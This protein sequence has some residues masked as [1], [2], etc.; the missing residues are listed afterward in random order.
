MFG[1]DNKEL[2]ITFDTNVRTRRADLRLEAGDYGNLLLD[3]D[4]MIMEIKT[5]GN[6]PLWLSQL[7]S[8]YRIYKT[9]FSKYGKEYEKMLINSEKMK[10]EL[11]KCLTQYSIQY[12]MQPQLVHQF[13]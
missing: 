1:K 6:I 4:Q 7:L 3:K 10:G 13:L 8:E 12:P 11:N 9:S 2:R 5:E